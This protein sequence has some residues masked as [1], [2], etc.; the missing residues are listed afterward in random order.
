MAYK[1]TITCAMCEREVSRDEAWNLRLEHT[2][3]EDKDD[4]DLCSRC[5]HK[6]FRLVSVAFIGS[7]ESE[8]WLAST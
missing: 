2:R 1:V 5:A 7:K 4:W 8:R 6:F 3:G